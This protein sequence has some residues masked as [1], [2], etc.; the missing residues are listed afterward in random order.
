[1]ADGTSAGHD[2]WSNVEACLGWEDE[3]EDGSDQEDFSYD[4]LVKFFDKDEKLGPKL[5]D[6]TLAMVDGA[7]RSPVPATKEKEYLD[8]LL[9]P[10]NSLGL[11]VPRTNPEV[12]T[13]IRRFTKD[14][15]FKL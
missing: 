12:W 8:K 10:E 14:F 4:E 5:N 9:R 3:N 11:I 7:L 1:M 2:T 6:A 15:D 13:E